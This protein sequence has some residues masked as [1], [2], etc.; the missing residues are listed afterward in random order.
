MKQPDVS[1]ARALPARGPAVELVNALLVAARRG[2]LSRVRELYADDA[3]AISPVFGEVRG[4]QA[5]ADTWQ[6]L[7]DTFTDFQTEISHVLVDGDQVAVLSSV[8]AT[9][10][11]GWFGAAPTGAPIRY[12]LVLLFAIADGKIVRDERIYDSAGVHERLQKARLDK[13]LRTAAEV[14]R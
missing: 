11:F 3:V 2:D 6:R 14:Q 4:P 9:D 10:R 5:I 8:E 13:E 7:F 1:A 12:K